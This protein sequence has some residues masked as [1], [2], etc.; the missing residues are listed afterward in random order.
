MH[1]AGGG[2]ERRKGG[3]RDGPMVNEEGRGREDSKSKDQTQR[4]RETS[5]LCGPSPHHGRP[6]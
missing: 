2:G 3:L 5:F 6:C 4:G 1:E